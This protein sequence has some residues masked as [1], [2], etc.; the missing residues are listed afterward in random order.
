MRVIYHHRLEFANLWHNECTEACALISQV[1]TCCSKA[2]MCSWR[3]CHCWA[4]TKLVLKVCSEE[5]PNIVLVIFD[6]ERSKV[7]RPMNS[8]QADHVVV[9]VVCE[10]VLIPTLRVQSALAKALGLCPTGRFGW[11]M[12]LNVSVPIRDLTPAN[13]ISGYPPTFSTHSTKILL[14]SFVER[15]C[16]TVL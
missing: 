5:R 8:T 11:R 12:P 13:N 2:S 4:A 10:A 7:R 3:L 14:V 1:S 16:S 6:F 9:G 15:S